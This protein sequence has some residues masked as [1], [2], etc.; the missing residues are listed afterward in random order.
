MV[1][2][3][4]KL[5]L[6]LIAIYFEEFIIIAGKSVKNYARNIYDVWCFPGF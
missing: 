4:N 1:K 6:I 3:H 2:T 5:L